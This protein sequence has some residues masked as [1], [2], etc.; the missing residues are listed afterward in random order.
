MPAEIKS[1]GDVN[2]V[3][4]V[5]ATV[6]LGSMPARAADSEQ[7]DKDFLEY[8]AEFEGKDDW[9]LFDGHDD[10]DKEQTKQPAPVKPAAPAKEKVE[11]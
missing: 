10:D 11:P 4:A 6:A 1:I 3:V 9:V 5:V 8:L 7:L 2:A